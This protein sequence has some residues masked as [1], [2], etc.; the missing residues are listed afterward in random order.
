M[1]RIFFRVTIRNIARNKVFTF[2]NVAGLA[3]GMAAS[4]LILLWVQDELSYDRFHSNAENIYRVEMNQNYSGDVYHVYVTPQP[5]GPVWKERIPEIVEQ[6]RVRRLSRTLFRHDDN[7]FFE[8]SLM[9]VDSGFFSVFSFPL[10]SGDP[11]DVL[12]SPNSI[13]LT[14]ELA[15]KYFGDTNPVGQ[16]LSLDNRY[17]FTVTGVIKDLPHNS[18]FT[19]DALLPYACLLYTSPSPRDRTRSRMPSSA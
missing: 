7:V 11:S 8:N 2:L 17:L 12:S 18:L 19:F 10:V 6:T 3:I 15:G 14:E 4:L 13:V 1:I 5:S 9:A 16:T